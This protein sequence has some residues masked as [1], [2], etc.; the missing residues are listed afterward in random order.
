MHRALDRTLAEMYSERWYSRIP[1]KCYQ[2]IGQAGNWTK[3][4]TRRLCYPAACQRVCM[5]EVPM[6]EFRE[7]GSLPPLNR[8]DTAVS[9]DDTA[10]K[11]HCEVSVLNG[12]CGILENMVGSGAFVA[13][14]SQGVVESD[15]TSVELDAKS[16]IPRR[17]SIIKV[18]CFRQDCTWRLGWHIWLSQWRSPYGKIGTPCTCQNFYM[19][20]I[21][22]LSIPPR[23]K[24]SPAKRSKDLQECTCNSECNCNIWLTK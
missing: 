7:D 23:W 2:T 3:A 21:H 11:T 16:E 8:G 18:C 22:F 4:E 15:N 5:L 17:S 12:D 9:S 1:C 13:P 24:L 20:P 6:A 19:N 10:G 14:C